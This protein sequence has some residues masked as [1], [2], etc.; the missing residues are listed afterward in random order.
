MIRLAGMVHTRPAR[1]IPAHDAGRSS[2]DR[3]AV[4]VAPGRGGAVPARRQV[5]VV[6]AAAHVRTSFHD[7]LR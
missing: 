1:S 5:V 3:A 4:V 2:P 7:G 6:D